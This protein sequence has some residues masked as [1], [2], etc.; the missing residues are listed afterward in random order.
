MADVRSMAGNEYVNRFAFGEMAINQIS[1]YA[2]P[3]F[4]DYV[5]DRIGKS[6]LYDL[7]GAYKMNRRDAQVAMSEKLE[8]MHKEYVSNHQNSRR[9]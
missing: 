3:R 4:I 2:E 9:N 6:S 8:N 7:V 1:G 5:L